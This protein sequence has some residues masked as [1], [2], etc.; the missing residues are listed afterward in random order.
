MNYV[1]AMAVIN[2]VNVK[3]ATHFTVMRRWIFAAFRREKKSW[4]NVAKA[5]F[6]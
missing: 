5:D 6:S 4:R 2:A 3:M 1:A